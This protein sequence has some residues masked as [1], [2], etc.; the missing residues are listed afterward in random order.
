MSLISRK[1]SVTPAKL[2]F[3]PTSGTPGQSPAQLMEVISEMEGHNFAP[4]VC[5]VKDGFNLTSMLRGAL[6]RGITTFVVCGGDGTINQVAIALAGKHATLGLVPTGTRNNVA[7]SLGIPSTIPEAVALLRNGKRVKVDVGQIKY[8]NRKQPFL[9]VCSVG[10]FSALYQSADEVQ[11]GNL[12]KVG[13]FLSK[14]F[15]TPPTEIRLTLD[16]KHTILSQG[17]GVVVNN[18]SFFGLNYQV[19]PAS[20]FMDGLLDVLVF[21]QMSKLDLISGAMQMA[22][23]E[24]QDPRIRRFQAKRVE[25][26]TTPVMPIMVDGTVLGEGKIRISLKP[27]TLAVM[28][29]DPIN[30]TTQLTKVSVTSSVSEPASTA[31]PQPVTNG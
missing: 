26:E 21:S 1:R 6:S 28:A 31:T 7:K 19:A 13:E 5:L 29:G 15:A 14:L 18:T 2:I 16:G 10:L 22:G 3:N 17:H 8:G 11:H 24:V 9:E 27:K 30:G 20:A 12:S 4:E 25:I 23:S